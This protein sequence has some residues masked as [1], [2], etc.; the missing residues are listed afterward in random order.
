MKKALTLS[1]DIRQ[2]TIIGKAGAKEEKAGSKSKNFVALHFIRRIAIVLHNV[3]EHDN[4]IKVS[5]K[6]IEMYK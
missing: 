1:E 6:K 2:M 5:Q 4:I 3:M